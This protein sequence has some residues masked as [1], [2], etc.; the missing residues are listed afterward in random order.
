MLSFY[1]G[2]YLGAGLSSAAMIPLL[3]WGAAGAKWGLK[4][5]EI[6]EQLIRGKNFEKQ[7]CLSLI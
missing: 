6:P 1:R 4:A 5:S 3:G 2:D 7:S